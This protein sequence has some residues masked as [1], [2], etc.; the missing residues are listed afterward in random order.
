MKNVKL[1]EE[2][3][4]EDVYQAF[5]RD[6]GKDAEIIDAYSDNEIVWARSTKKTFNNGVPVLKYIARS[7]K[8]SVKVK[9]GKVTVVNDKKYGWWYFKQGDTW[10]GMNHDNWDRLPFDH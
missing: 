10:Y 6:L 8:N 4:N 9:K 1:F 5:L 7:E 3:L 2:F